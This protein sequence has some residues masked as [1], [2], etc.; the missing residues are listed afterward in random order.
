[1]NDLKKTNK[2]LYNALS[3]TKPGSAA[4]DKRWKALAQSRP[5]E[6]QAAQ[7]NYIKKSYYDPA[8][9]KVKSA[10]GIDINK[11]SKAVQ[12]ALWS[13]AVQHGTG[14][15]LKVFKNASINNRLS[16]REIITRIYNERAANN[17]KK[18][19]SRSSANI[20]QGVINRFK[21]EMKDALSMLGI[22]GR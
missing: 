18:Y 10:L 4:F 7:H 1:M 22:G 9:R 19:F 11:R 3:P 17:G 2:S 15:A 14:G 5:K 12:D 13:T 8:A 20:R 21:R 16:D 6:F